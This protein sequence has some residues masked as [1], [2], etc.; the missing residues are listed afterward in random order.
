MSAN[1]NRERSVRDFFIR[2]S[3]RLN[4]WE[5]LIFI[6]ENKGPMSEEMRGFRK[7]R[8]E[9][10]HVKHSFETFSIRKPY[11]RV[12]AIVLSNRSIA[13]NRVET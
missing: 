12:F 11:H 8:Q 1:K 3:E 13:N 10:F 2:R 9:M 4:G 5:D 6:C 7:R